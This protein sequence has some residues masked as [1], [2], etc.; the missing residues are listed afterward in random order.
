[1]TSD[2]WLGVVSA[3]S[4]Y[5]LAIA[6]WSAVCLLTDRFRRSRMPPWVRREMDADA[7]TGVDIRTVWEGRTKV[8]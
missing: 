7:W 6:G 4:V 2:F 8:E 5:M 1:M 3:A